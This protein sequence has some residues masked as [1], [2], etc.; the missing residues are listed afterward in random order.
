MRPILHGDVIAAA[1]AVMR[2][3]PEMQ[4]GALQRLLTQAQ[5]ADS[6]SKRTGRA[7]PLWGNGSLFTAAL[8]PGTAAPEPDLTDAAYLG[9]LGRVTDAIIEWRCRPCTT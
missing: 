8:P 9:A 2:L 1:R 5:M 6:Y 3:P 4:A 7:H